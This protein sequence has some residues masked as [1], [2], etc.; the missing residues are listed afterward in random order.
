[1]ST[2]A[3]RD[4]LASSADAGTAVRELVALAEDA[5]GPDNISVIVIDV[6]DSAVELR[7]ADPVTLGAA[8][9]GVL[10]S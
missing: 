7:R 6:R 1:V 10:T 9:A 8:A 2:E 4:V 5:G 3:I